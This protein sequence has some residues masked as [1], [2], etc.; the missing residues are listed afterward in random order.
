MFEAPA[1]QPVLDGAF[2]DNHGPH[3]FR[4][5]LVVV[6]SPVQTDEVPIAELVGERRTFELPASVWQIMS[7]C[8]AVF[9]IA[10]LASTGGGRAGFAIAVSAIYIAMFFGTARMITRQG[11][12]QEPAPVRNPGTHLQTAFGPMSRGAVFG[13]IL[14]V[15]LAVAVFGIAIAIVI[16]VIA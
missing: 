5:T 4:P 6:T 3:L 8:Y 10:L 11:P 13:Q 7:A 12:Q 16:A 2:S 15:P 9:L 14:I 1:S